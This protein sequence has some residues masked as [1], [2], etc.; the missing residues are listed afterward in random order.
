LCLGLKDT[1]CEADV[2]EWVYKTEVRSKLSSNEELVECSI[3]LAHHII[4]GGIEFASQFGF[5][6]HK[7]FELSR[8]VLDDR[9]SIQPC[10]EN[11]EFGKD[12]EP[13]FVAGPYDDVERIIR[14][15]ESKAGEGKFSSI[16]GFDEDLF[17]EDV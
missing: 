6:P 8:H 3:P 17:D 16:T 10:T 7:D 2:S 14:Q 4:Y 15:L 11:V 9:D 12:G 1:L 13:L 5:K